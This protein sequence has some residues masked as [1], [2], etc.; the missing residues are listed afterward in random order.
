MTHKPKLLSP[1][2]STQSGFTIVESLLAIIIVS[3]L[4]VAIAPVITLSVATRLQSRRV[5]LATAAARSYID[6]VRAGNIPPPSNLIP[7]RQVASNGRNNAQQRYQSLAFTGVPALQPTG[8]G[9][10]QPVANPNSAKYPFYC[11]N[12]R[13]VSLYCVDGDGD[14]ACKNSSS[15]DLIVQAF[16]STSTNPPNLNQD[17]GS[18]G[19]LMGIRVYRA[20]AFDG[21]TQLKTMQD[22]GV[23]KA[24]TF[25]GGTGDRTAPLT[26]ITTEVGGTPKNY[27]KNLCERLGGC[28]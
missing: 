22:K 15:K 9:D 8:F 1:P 27:Y 6:G 14:G 24:A 18:N 11:V 19:Y 12:T 17:D 13:S 20:D 2:S 3:V 26:E 25:A 4:L 21:S 23:K 7:I 16:R 5:E 28:S 10:C